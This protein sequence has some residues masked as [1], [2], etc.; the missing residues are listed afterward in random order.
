M[1]SVFLLYSFILTAQS[2]TRLS[3]GSPLRALDSSIQKIAIKSVS[4][5]QFNSFLLIITLLFYEF[6][7][8]FYRFLFYFLL[9]FLYLFRNA[10]T[11]QANWNT[12]C[13]HKFN[14]I[15]I[16]SFLAITIVCIAHILFYNQF[17]F[18]SLII[19]IFF[20]L[21]NH[22]HHFFIFVNQDKSKSH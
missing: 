3:G 19:F 9:F 7:S 21:H 8:A 20:V 12:I 5:F 14:L 15:Q 10:I 13:L 2:Q 11:K 17:L 18:S 6:E 4:L 1:R 22:N 16:V